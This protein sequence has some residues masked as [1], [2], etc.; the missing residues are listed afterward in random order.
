VRL[1]RQEEFAVIKNDV[2]HLKED[3]AELKS[4]AAIN[5]A[6]IKRLLETH[7]VTANDAHK[8]FRAEFASKWVEKVTI[9]AVLAIISL[10]LGL[11]FKGGVS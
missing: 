2:K 9:G 7:A 8:S 1:T 4:Q 11:V 5:F 3:I 6:E 10:I